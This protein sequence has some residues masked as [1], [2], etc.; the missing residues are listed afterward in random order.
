MENT[1][2]NF[3]RADAR[4]G[5]KRGCGATCVKPKKWSENLLRG[6]GASAGWRD[7]LQKRDAYSEQRSATCVKQRHSR[8]QVVIV[9][10]F[11]QF[12]TA[13]QKTSC[14]CGNHNYK[15]LPWMARLKDAL[16]EGRGGRA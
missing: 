1:P 9:I 2:Q 11:S 4:L 12:P 8:Q 15:L 5:V 10:C 16:K 7:D 3:F 14:D 6:C 13:S